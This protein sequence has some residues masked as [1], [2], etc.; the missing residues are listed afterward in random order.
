MNMHI[1]TH[2]CTK[3]ACVRRSL[4]SNDDCTKTLTRLLASIHLMDTRI[5]HLQ[6]NFEEKSSI[7]PLGAANDFIDEAPMSQAKVS[8]MEIA[9]CASVDSDNEWRPATR[10]L[11]RWPPPL[12]G[13]VT[14]E[15]PRTSPAVMLGTAHTGDS[16]VHACNA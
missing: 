10:N 5:A 2:I 9:R 13:E 7:D 4:E 11:S 6:K 15:S 16:S 1:Q 3:L 12:S 8:T 14:P